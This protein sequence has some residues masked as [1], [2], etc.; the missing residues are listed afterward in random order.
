[1][2]SQCVMFPHRAC[3]GKKS[4]EEAGQF[5]NFPYQIAYLMWIYGIISHHQ[6]KRERIAS[7]RIRY[8]NAYINA[9]G[10]THR[11]KISRYYIFYDLII[12]HKIFIIYRSIVMNDLKIYIFFNVHFSLSILLL[13]YLLYYFIIF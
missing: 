11:F 3:L 1:M 10:C 13:F 2:V 5:F 9:Q 8:L 12:E 4:H 7:H 6:R